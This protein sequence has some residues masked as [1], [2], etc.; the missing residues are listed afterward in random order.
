MPPIV[1]NDDNHPNNPARI[2]S[3]GLINGREVF[4]VE[5]HNHNGYVLVN[6]NGDLAC[7]HFFDSIHEAK[8]EA[9]RQAQRHL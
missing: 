6:F 7:N 9:C 5:Y 1:W 8:A 3:I 2:V 4:A